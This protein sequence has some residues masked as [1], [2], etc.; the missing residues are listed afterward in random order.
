MAYIN[1]GNN[2]QHSQSQTTT[3]AFDDAVRVPMEGVL[4]SQKVIVTSHMK[5]TR[6]TKNDLQFIE[7]HLTTQRN[8]LTTERTLRCNWLVVIDITVVLLC[9]GISGT[10]YPLWLIT[11]HLFFVIAIVV[12]DTV[13]VI[14]LITRLLIIF[15]NIILNAVCTQPFLIAVKD[16]VPIVIFVL[17]RRI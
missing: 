12:L 1:F 4:T 7:C 6:S 2:N 9:D 10:K 13:I 11:G 5:C 15:D 17:R 16:I 14:A 3:G 8:V